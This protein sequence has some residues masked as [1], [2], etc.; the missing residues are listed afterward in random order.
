MVEGTGEPGSAV[1]P[2]A[3]V[4][5]AAPRTVPGMAALDPNELKGAAYEIFVLLVS[6]LS[7]VNTLIVL[8]PFAWQI[9]Q[10]AIL[11]DG[12]VVPVFAF[13]FG[14]RF[15]TARSRS[16]YLWRRFGWADFLAIA[17]T[18]GAFRIFRVVRVLRLFRLQS[19]AVILEEL[20]R[21]RARATFLL[22]LW[23]VIVVVE[24]A[25]IGVY[26]VE[27]PAPGA[28][29]TDAGDAIWWGFVT[30]T[31]VGYGDQYPITEAGR[32]IGTILL[33]AGIAL[34]SVLTGFI[35]NTFLAPREGRVR[36]LRGAKPTLDDEIESLRSMLI[37]AEKNA[38]AIR[39]KLDDIERSADALRR[40]R[41]ES[42]EGETPR[43][44]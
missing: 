20:D 12:L 40:E 42:E 3:A 25:G 8:L 7:V 32:I 10:V 24:F 21:S 11:V 16:S 23:L 2:Q 9:K 38:T 14:Y 5:K 17:P 27:S 33:F 28:N 41:R 36:R 19:G 44:T 15:L 18:L 31:T 29:I 39:H 6:M 35:A 37:Q 26:L 4:P 43:P 30:I 22:T 13:D 1:P 34:F